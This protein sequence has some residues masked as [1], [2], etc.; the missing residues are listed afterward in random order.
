MNPDGVKCGAVTVVNNIIVHLPVAKR[1]DLES[2]HY[3]KKN[4][5]HEL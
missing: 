5:N 4:C 1:V 2:S 3:K